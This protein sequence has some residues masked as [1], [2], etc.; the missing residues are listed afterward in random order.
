MQAAQLMRLLSSAPTAARLYNAWQRAQRGDREAIEYLRSEGWAEALDMLVAP[1]AGG[2]AKEALGHAG[3][4]FRV[5]HGLRPQ[6][7]VVDAEYRVV[8]EEE[9]SGPR[10]P[11]MGFLGR[12][13][14]Q[15]HGAHLVIGPIGSGKTSLAVKMAHRLSEIH[16]YR[17][18]VVNVYKDD[19]PSWAVSISQE[20]LIKRMK[21]LARHLDSMAVDD[22][23]EGEDEQEQLIEEENEPVGLP[24]T[25]RVIII[26]EASLGLGGG[27]A[28]P[29]RKA[30]IQ[31]L[32]Q[33]RHLR[34]HVLFVAQWTGLL[35]LALLGQSTCWIKKPDGREAYTDRDN[36]AVK[37]LWLRA[38]EA[39]AGL[40]QSEWYTGEWRDPRA[41]AY[42]DCQSLSGKPGYNGL[43]PFTPVGKDER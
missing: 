3:E 11:W 26:D 37:A 12:M 30:A 21:K 32:T 8:E 1:G 35:P 25:D 18:E 28:S 20:T 29:A 27:Y 34:W 14:R 33:C 5:L 41:W 38:N 36:P 39:F 4:A 19:A 40:K 7:D 31:A 15:D 23:D 17:V 2:V 9:A 6:G 13:F 22:E 16:G 10:P 43:V 42:C 24:P